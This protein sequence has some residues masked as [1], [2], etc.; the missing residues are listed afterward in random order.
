M[1]FIVGITG[2]IGSGKSAVASLLEGSDRDP[3][4]VSALIASMVQYAGGL[5]MD[6]DDA[7]ERHEAE[8]GGQPALE[9]DEA[10]SLI[11]AR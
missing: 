2:G 3:N 11:C 1:A 4:M 6:A 9:E 8:Q 7:D 5:A 10:S